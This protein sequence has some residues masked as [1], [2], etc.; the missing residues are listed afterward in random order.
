MDVSGTEA[1]ED[2]EES[3]AAELVGDFGP[4]VDSGSYAVDAEPSREDVD[5]H[6]D[7]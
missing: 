2:E 6:F 3:D 5:S 7:E 4:V 1:L